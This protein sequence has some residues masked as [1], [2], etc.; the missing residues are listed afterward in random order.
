MDIQKKKNREKNF[1]FRRFLLFLRFSVGKGRCR[2]ERRSGGPKPG[3]LPLSA[4][5]STDA[6]TESMLEETGKAGPSAAARDDSVG[7]K[8][9]MEKAANAFLLA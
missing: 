3:N 4:D 8:R 5:L 9:G 1:S 7:Q 6:L 2:S